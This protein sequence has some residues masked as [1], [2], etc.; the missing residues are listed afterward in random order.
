M[1]ALPDRELWRVTADGELV[2][3]M[4]SLSNVLGRV[5]ELE[6]EVADLERDMRRARARER[7]LLSQLEDDR[8]GYGRRDEVEDIFNEWRRVCGHQNARL[9]MDR[10]DV[11]RKLLEVSRPAAYPREAFA[12]AFAGAA[13][14]PFVT[15]RRNG[16]E[17]RH[18]DIALIC[19]DGKTFESFIRR[20]PE[21]DVAA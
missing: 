7:W 10:F 4:P 12:A 8:A 13:Y 19:R 9:T 15:R 5:V 20:A 16:S 6:A 11:I 1:V 14:D 21:G 2:G 18:D 17:H 3:D